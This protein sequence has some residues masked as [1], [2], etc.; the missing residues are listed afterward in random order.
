MDDE[1]DASTPWEELPVDR[2]A[3]HIVSQHHSY[4]RRE[5]PALG[6]LAAWVKT[7]HRPRH[8]ELNEVEALVLDLRRDLDSHLD[9]EEQL[10]ADLLGAAPPTVGSPTAALALMTYEHE[11]TDALLD[12]L[13]QVT[14]DYE[15]PADA[16]DSYRDLYARLDHLD[17]DTRLHTEKEDRR[18]FPLIVERISEEPWST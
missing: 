17:R 9:R 18:L 3:R 4:L 12:T 14:A 6:P 1:T 15:V 8:V 16:D 10:V 7:V 13:R 11:R 2:L 5:L